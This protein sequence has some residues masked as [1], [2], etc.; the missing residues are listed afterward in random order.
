MRS[1]TG[2]KGALAVAL[3]VGLL[4]ACYCPPHILIALLAV[5][6][7]LLGIAFVKCS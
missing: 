1:S 6:V 2:N 5:V 3:G 4:F 7:I